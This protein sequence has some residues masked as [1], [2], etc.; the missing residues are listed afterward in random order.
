MER[1]DAFIN[2]ERVEFARGVCRA[3]GVADTAVAS[4]VPI[5]DRCG[6]AWRKQTCGS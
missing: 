2:M 5:S 1:E 6:Y 4:A 3:A